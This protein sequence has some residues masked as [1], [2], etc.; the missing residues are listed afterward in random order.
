MLSQVK[1]E[2]N[3]FKNQENGV[4]WLQLQFK[5]ISLLYENSYKSILLLLWKLLYYNK[6]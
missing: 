6:Y 5:A 3:N 4:K 1:K 2:E